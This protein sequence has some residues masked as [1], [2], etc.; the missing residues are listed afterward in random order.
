MY[1]SH[2]GH[3]YALTRYGHLFA[4]DEDL[5]REMTTFARDEDSLVRDAHN[6]V[7]LW[8]HGS[9]NVSMSVSASVHFMTKHPNSDLQRHVCLIEAVF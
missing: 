4:R 5:S 7:R 9:D 1:M 3:E 8:V 2:A 6:T